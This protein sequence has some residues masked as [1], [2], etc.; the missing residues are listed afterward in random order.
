[1][2]S[3]KGFLFII[4]GLFILSGFSFV[5]PSFADVDVTGS[6]QLVKSPL[7]YNRLTKTSYLDVSLKNT[8]QAALFSHLTVVI[9]SI[10]T[11]SVTVANADG[12]TSDG[13]FYFKY[14][15]VNTLTPGQTTATKRWVFSN[16]SAARFTYT[17]RVMTVDA[18]KSIGSEGGTVEVMDPA[19]LIYGARAEIPEG[20]I[21]PEEST[22]VTIEVRNEIPGPL[23]EGFVAAGPVVTISKN[24]P[25]SFSL[26]VLVTIPFDPSIVSSGG[27]PV[28]F[29]WDTNY[30][31]YRELGLKSIDWANNTLSFTTIH[32]TDFMAQ[33]G[34]WLNNVPI[35]TGF[36]PRADGFSLDNISAG[37]GSCLG[38]V[39]YANWFFSYIRPGTGKR[40]FAEYDGDHFL[41]RELALRAI[42]GTSQKIAS[43]PSSQSNLGTATGMV[44]IETMK[45]TGSPQILLFPDVGHAVGVYEYTINTFTPGGLFHIYDPNAS[46]SE[47]PVDCDKLVLEWNPSEGFGRYRY[48]G[49]FERD[50]YP[51]M[52]TSLIEFESISSAINPYDYEHLY[53][54]A[55]SNFDPPGFPKITLTSHDLHAV[56]LGIQG[57]TMGL[58]VEGPSNLELSGTVTSGT[59]VPKELICLVNQDKDL[60]SVFP[61]NDDGS[62]SLQIPNLPSQTNYV[63]LFAVQDSDNYNEVWGI[64]KGFKKYS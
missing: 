43:S 22:E 6:V 2:K 12:T 55:E 61:I 46:C 15:F 13:K 11:A 1:M 64:Q 50:V 26:P 40:L 30:G 56:D 24:S 52:N 23:V 54:G 47:K 45:S 49:G 14:T 19:S 32:F 27:V 42:Y 39:G 44:L 17:V 38:M 51:G 16:P 31:T 7:G 48:E 33:F 57:G 37:S 58:T 62:F 41:Q 18:A 4:I 21:G 53:T 28:P 10:S 3:K 8:G 63:L 25:G 60:V 20:A 9:D 35:F 34:A 29:Y 5:T 59:F 36:S